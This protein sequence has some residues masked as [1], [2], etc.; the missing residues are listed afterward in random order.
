[1]DLHIRIAAWRKHKGLTQSG[2]AA[3]VRDLGGKASGSAVSYWEAGTSSP[4][5]ANLSIVVLALGLTMA[6]F[7]GPLPVAVAEA[8]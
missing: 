7:Y 6:E 8:S 2:L 5:Q 1:M 4:T 3:R